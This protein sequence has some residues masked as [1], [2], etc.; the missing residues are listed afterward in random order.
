[1]NWKEISEGLTESVINA[2]SEELEIHLFNSN[3]S[4]YDIA[5]VC[6]VFTANYKQVD[7]DGN[8][9]STREPVVEISKNV[10]PRD[11]LKK[12]DKIKARGDLYEIREIQRDSSSAIK[13]YLTR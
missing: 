6:G 10:L 1:M 8:L 5:L 3:S 4:S 9:L 2:F 7:L 12:R 11:L 13:I